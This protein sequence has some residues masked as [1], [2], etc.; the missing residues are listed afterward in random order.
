MSGGHGSS[1]RRAYGRRQKALRDRP[2]AELSVDLDG[3]ARW[4]RGTAWDNG[5]SS[6]PGHWQLSDGR[7]SPGSAR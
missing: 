2:D 3:P 7:Q 1:R 5:T 4:P 6:G